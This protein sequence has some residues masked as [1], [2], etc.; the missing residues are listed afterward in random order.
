KIKGDIEELNE[1]DVDMIIVLIHWGEEYHREPSQYQI[2][3]GHKMVDWGA[4]IILGSHPHV[5]QKSEIVEKDG[6]DN[7]IIYSMG[8]F[9]SN[10][11]KETM[12]NAYAEDGVI[13]Q[14]DLEKDLDNQE[15][16]IKNIEFMPT[17][18]HK[19]IEDNDTHYKI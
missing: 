7:Y 13:V 12:G 5:I 3:L 16:N 11:R 18:I 10:Q 2:E 14:I 17:W 1:K 4:N 15:T 6:R 8:N 19:Y 9:L